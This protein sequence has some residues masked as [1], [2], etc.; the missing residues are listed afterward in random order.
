MG[1]RTPRMC[2]GQSLL[3]LQALDDLGDDGGAGARGHGAVGPHL[4]VGAVISLERRVP[5]ALEEG[6]PPHLVEERGQ[7]RAHLAEAL[8]R[9]AD[10]LHRRRVLHGAGGGVGDDQALEALGVGGGEVHREQTSE[11]VTEEHRPLRVDG[12]DHTQDVGRVVGHR[13]TL[14]RLVALAPAAQIDP[15][16]APDCREPRADEPLEARRVRG[17]AVKEHERR[18]PRAAVVE[19]PDLH[20]FRGPH[21]ATLCHAH[22]RRPQVSQRTRAHAAACDPVPRWY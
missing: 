4:D 17:Q 9:R 1:W 20:P 15:E 22:P 18:V 3:A 21:L 8:D 14:G 11:R 13:V 19:E 2:A 6:H 10:E 7:R 12:V 16:G 5:A